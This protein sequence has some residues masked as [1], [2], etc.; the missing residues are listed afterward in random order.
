MNALIALTV[1]AASFG[2]PQ[3]GEKKSATVMTSS[4]G[5]KVLFVR[6]EKTGQWRPQG[7][8]WNFCKEDGHWYRQVPCAV[9][10]AACDCTT[11]NNCGCMSHAPAQ[12]FYQPMYYP[13]TY[14]FGGFRGISGGCA[15][16][17]CR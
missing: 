14:G 2:T 8:G 17:N 4:T 12:Q 6:D 15:G 1:A 7:K 13:P 9:C 10:G 11:G 5:N 3:E 16:G